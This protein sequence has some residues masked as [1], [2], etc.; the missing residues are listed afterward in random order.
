MREPQGPCRGC[1]H[2]VAENPEK[3]LKDCHGTCTKY[4][5]YRKKIEEYHEYLK[6]E[7]GNEMVAKNR[8]WLHH[9]KAVKRNDNKK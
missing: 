7:K 3:G 2:R 8:P 4:Q 6:I 1:D 5:E 9:R